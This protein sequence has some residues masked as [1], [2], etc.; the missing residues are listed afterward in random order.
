MYRGEFKSLVLKPTR[1][2]ME[3]QLSRFA[4]T[5]AFEP[6][7][8][9]KE[10]YYSLFKGYLM[11]ADPAHLEPKFLAQ[12]SIHVWDKFAPMLSAGVLE[13]PVKA[14]I[15]R[16]LT[17]YSFQL[18]GKWPEEV[19]LDSSLIQNVRAV[20]RRIPLKERLYNQTINEASGDLEP[21]TLRVALEGYQQPNLVSEYEIPGVFTRYGWNTSF[22]QTLSEVLEHFGQEHWVLG[23]KEPLG[24]QLNQSIESEY[25]GD[26]TQHWYKFLQSIRIRS[27]DSSADVLNLLGAMR[28]NPSPI[29]ML[30]NAVKTNTGLVENVTVQT[31]EK[32]TSFIQK[33]KQK[34]LSEEQA[35]E[36]KPAKDRPYAFAFK[37]PV[38]QE[39]KSIH[40]FMTSPDEKKGIPSPLDQY[41]GEMSRVHGVLQGALPSQGAMQDPVVLAQAIAQGEPNDL[42]KSINTVEQLTLSLDPHP[43][44]ILEPLLVKPILLA[45]QGV[46]NR[47][48]S[49]V[50]ERWDAAV[51]GPCQQ[52][53]AVRYPFQQDGEDIT[54]ADVSYFFHPQNGV[55]WGFYGKQLKPFIH[56]SP[57]HWEVKQWRGVSLPL[58]QTVIDFLE[59]A[60]S[61]SESLF[62][63]GQAGPNVSFDLYPYPD[64]GPSASQVSQI[65]L[66]LGEQEL[67]YS[68]GPQE[69]QAMLW[70]GT[71]GSAGALLQVKLDGT[72]EQR[73]AQGWWGLFRLLESA[74]VQPVTDSTYRVMWAFESRHAQP[75]RIQYDLKARSS[76]NPFR[77]DFFRQFSCLSNL[78]QS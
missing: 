66:K 32:D 70:P 43:K 54:L 13:E 58:S 23:E 56:S 77:K 73:E 22:R 33:M 35:P 15:D 40:K 37:D 21:F 4:T 44:G 6:E 5:Y 19:K 39:F 65:R 10:D 60:W 69:S 17:F 8:K 71:D 51:Y 1:Q 16:L 9:G 63:V 62:P 12:Q 29:A 26:F 76:R 36:P 27:N 78:E 59:N 64:Q 72:W 11:I 57:Q 75:L 42:S 34:L 38:Y 68:M 47:A 30:L 53:I 3:A 74:D 7:L 61:I 28:T 24:S 31:G 48:L 2:G 50:N 18:A 45:M 67:L 41:L 52:M 49:K 46:T 25:F 20:F 55:L 14:A